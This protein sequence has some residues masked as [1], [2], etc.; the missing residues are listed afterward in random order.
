MDRARND[1]HL[2]QSQSKLQAVKLEC[3][4]G[5]SILQQHLC[6]LK[7]SHPRAQK[8]SYHDA[9]TCCCTLGQKSSGRRAA[10]MLDANH[11]KL[12]L[13]LQTAAEL[14]STIRYAMLCRHNLFPHFSFWVSDFF[15]P[16][17]WDSEQQNGEHCLKTGTHRFWHILL[18]TEK[19][20]ERG[21]S[22]WT[23]LGIWKLG[24]G[25]GREQRQR[26][27]NV[28]VRKAGGTR[29]RRNSDTESGKLWVT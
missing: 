21:C 13:D 4:N 8:I 5:Y 15:S 22:G 20:L 17:Q 28:K 9:T 19:E 27:A 3:L 18:H 12:L 2:T 24:S 26:R 14:W 1:L 25:E 29:G 6:A 7:I 10:V 16:S 23:H 11:Q